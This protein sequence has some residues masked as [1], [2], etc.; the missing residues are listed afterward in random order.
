MPLFNMVTLIG[1][2]SVSPGG[3]GVLG[4]SA[5]KA[6]VILPAWPVARWLAP[7]ALVLAA[8]AALVVSYALVLLRRA[9]GGESDGRSRYP[10]RRSKV[11]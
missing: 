3:L 2:S 11:R 10:V 6:L 5:L 4:H 8:E 7:P 9:K 1:L